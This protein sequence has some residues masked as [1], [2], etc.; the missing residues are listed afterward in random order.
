ML[1]DQR[2]TNKFFTEENNNSKKKTRRN[3]RFYHI[4]MRWFYSPGRWD[5]VSFDRLVLHDCHK[6]IKIVHSRKNHQISTIICIIIRFLFI[7]NFLDFFVFWICVRSSWHKRRSPL[8]PRDPANKRI[9][10]CHRTNIQFYLWYCVLLRPI[11]MCG[12]ACVLGPLRWGRAAVSYDRLWWSRSLI[13]YT[14]AI[15]AFVV[16]VAD[17][18]FYSVW[19]HFDCI[20][21]CVVALCAYWRRWRHT[22]GSWSDVMA[23]S[24]INKHSGLLFQEPKNRP[25]PIGSIMGQVDAAVFVMF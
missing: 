15:L 12:Y 25:Q 24:R 2:N 22:Y 8:Q 7:F 20:A 6:L 5:S 17:T 18:S 10:A 19:Q 13:V 11:P 3:S 14:L 21:V 1:I 4:Q 23:G 16:A 9:L